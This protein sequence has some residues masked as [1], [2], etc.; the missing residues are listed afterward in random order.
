MSTSPA[1]QSMTRTTAAVMTY[2]LA[3]AG[4][5]AAITRVAFAAPARR[6][7]AVHFTHVAHRAGAAAAIWAHN[8]TIAVGFAMFLG[9]AYLIQREERPAR[10][11]RTILRA[12][13]AALVLWGSGTAVLAGVLAGAYGLT[14]IRAFLPQGPVELAAWTL[15]IVLYT[16]VRSRRIAAARAA[17]ELAIVLLLLAAAAVLEL[18][19][20]A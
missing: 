7:L 6:L 11:E 9:C 14:Q 10:I 2:L 16:Q 1:S 19:L 12:A 18:W 13:D 5:A 4:A 15:L 3:L 17:Y 20:G 8:A